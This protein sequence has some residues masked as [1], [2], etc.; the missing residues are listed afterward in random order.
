MYIYIYIHHYG[1]RA[2]LFYYLCPQYDIYL[3]S[4]REIFAVRKMI[5]FLME[6]Y[7]EL[8]LKMFRI[9]TQNVQD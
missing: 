7:S 3:I 1:R 6:T 9:S 5:I 8:V 2:H 4:F